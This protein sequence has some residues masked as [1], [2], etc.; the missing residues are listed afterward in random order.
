MLSD[1]V[2]VT[3]RSKAWTVFTHSNTG[4][5][6]SNPT[7][8]M[9][10]CVRLSCVCVG[11]CVGS[12]LPKG[13]SPVQCVLSTVCRIKEPKKWATALQLDVVLLLMRLADLHIFLRIH[14]WV[15]E[16]LADPF[17]FLVFICFCCFCSFCTVLSY[18]CYLQSYSV[19][20]HWLLSSARK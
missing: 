16:T 4:I 12:G 19:I 3:A 7:Q 11:L 2:A 6:G 13:W 8:G 15:L 1:P 10:V 18:C 5:V 17:P 14:V 20:D 9:D